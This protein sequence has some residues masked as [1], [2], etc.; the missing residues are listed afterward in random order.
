MNS[1]IQTQNLRSQPTQ[2]KTDKKSVP[3]PPPEESVF[4]PLEFVGIR[5]CIPR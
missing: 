4:Q 1:T 5:K 2:P 3:A